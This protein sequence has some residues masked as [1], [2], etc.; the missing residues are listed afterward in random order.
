MIIG[1]VGKPSSGK[2]SFFKASTLAEIDIANY[3]FTTLKANSAIGYVNIKCVDTEFNT[4]CNPRTGYCHNHIRFIPINLMDVPGLVPGAHKGFGMGFQFL[5]DLR[6]AD[7]L[8]HVID[9]SGSTNEK[10]E[11]VN[12]LSYDPL[13]DVE[14]LEDEIN[15]WFLDILKRGWEKSVRMLTQTKENTV[16][17]IAKQLSGLNVTEEHVES[18]LRELNMDPENPKSWNNDDLTNFAKSL[19]IKTKPIVI[20]ANKIDVSGADNNVKRIKE[21]FPHLIIIP[22]SAQSEIAL[23][24]A[25]KSGLIKYIPGNNDFEILKPE[26]LNKEQKKG[27]MLIKENVL[28]KYGTTGI[29]NVLN[30]VVF[31][32]L[33]YIAIFPGGLNK[34]SDQYG[35][36]LPDCFLMPPKTTALDFAFK[37]HTDIGNN[38]IKAIDVKTKRAV[39]KE[40]ILSHRDVIEIV[41]KK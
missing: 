23:K 14:F 8:I 3:P 4:Q 24:L 5:D 28:N 7:V 2:S 38:F 18:T 37:I 1:L 17:Y 26:S 19:R 36:I 40:H 32:I 12:P 22:C 33:K 29:Q 21:K 11:A 30:T 10:G 39:G 13:N 41:T 31:D 25:S 27:L 6:Q 34:L 15:F 20:A 9:I 35:N 16:K